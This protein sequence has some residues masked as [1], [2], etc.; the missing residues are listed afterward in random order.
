MVQ[1]AR[2]RSLLDMFLLNGYMLRKLCALE[3]VQ[4]TT[5]QQHLLGETLQVPCALEHICA[6]ITQETMNGNM[7]QVLC[8]GACMFHPSHSKKT[9]TN[10]R[11]DCASEHVSL[12]HSE[13]YWLNV[14]RV[15]YLGTLNCTS[16]HKT[17]TLGNL[18]DN[19]VLPSMY[20][21]PFTQQTRL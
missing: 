7:L 10:L 11:N 3:H 16:S 21:S 8:F 15:L 5:R 18:C 13:S 20:D 12:S 4:F 19:L 6:I 9:V 14:A 17:K 2:W 1:E